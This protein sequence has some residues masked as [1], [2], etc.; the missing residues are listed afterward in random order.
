MAQPIQPATTSSKSSN[1]IPKKKWIEN[2]VSKMTATKL[3][4]ATTNEAPRRKYNDVLVLTSTSQVIAATKNS[5][6]DQISAP[7]NNIT[8]TVPYPAVAN[9]NFPTACRMLF[10]FDETS[11][12]TNADN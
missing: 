6:A 1:I 8:L 5:P 4:K 11:S 12:Q 2:Q 7:T 9:P 3:V 10:L